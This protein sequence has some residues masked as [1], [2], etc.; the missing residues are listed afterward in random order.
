[1]LSTSIYHSADSSLNDYLQA[2]GGC[3]SSRYAYSYRTFQLPSTGLYQVSLYARSAA[4]SGCT[5]YARLFLDDVLVHNVYNPG[6]ALSYYTYQR[7]LSQGGHQVKVG[8]YT[9]KI[10]SGTFTSFTDD[11]MVGKTVSPA[12]SATFSPAD[13]E[14]GGC[15]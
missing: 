10:C 3:Q 1:M 6:P 7:S 9:T 8:M 5:M 4:C 13:E 12:P 2:S 15:L 11:I 14:G